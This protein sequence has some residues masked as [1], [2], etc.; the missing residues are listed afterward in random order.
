M[1]RDRSS[2]VVPTGDSIIIIIIIIICVFYHPRIRRGNAF[3]RIRLSVC[4]LRAQTFEG[5]DLE[6][7]FLACG[8]SSENLG[9]VRISRSSD[10]GQGHR[11]SLIHI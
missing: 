6:I 10:Q 5:L 1:V 8:T 7:S 11:L 2:Y 9:H 4:P 3:G